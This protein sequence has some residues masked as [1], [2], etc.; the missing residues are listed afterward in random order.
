MRSQALLLRC[1]LTPLVLVPYEGRFLVR[2]GRNLQRSSKNLAPAPAAEA[3][4]SRSAGQRDE[5]ALLPVWVL[6]LE[7]ASPCPCVAQRCTKCPVVLHGGGDVN[8]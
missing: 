3:W 7:V 4:D 6:D 2:I 5:E 1:R 8:R